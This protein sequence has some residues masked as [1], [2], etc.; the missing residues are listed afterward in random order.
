MATARAGKPEPPFA[1]GHVA[2]ISPR[3]EGVRQ[4]G[5]GRAGDAGSIKIPKI[6]AAHSA[7]SEFRHRPHFRALLDLRDVPMPATIFPVVSATCRRR[8]MLE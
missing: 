5:E 3:M 7:L 8:S 6:V 2:M 4:V 1:F